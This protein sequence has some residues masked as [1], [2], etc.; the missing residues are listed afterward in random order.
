L[1][2][3]GLLLLAASAW[4]EMGSARRPAW[5]FPA[6]LLVA[7]TVTIENN[8]SIRLVPPLALLGDASYSIYL[9]HTLTVSA[10]G[11]FK[12]YFNPSAFF[13]ASLTLSALIGVAAW[14][15]VE[16]PFAEFLKPRPR[17]RQPHFAE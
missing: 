11:K 6:F 10:I 15:L 1:K 13:I 4:L 5:G 16:R 8:R 14:R 9:T 7:A 17:I 12:A 3:A 2:D